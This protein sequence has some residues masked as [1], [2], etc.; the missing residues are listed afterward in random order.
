[1]CPGW[2]SCDSERSTLAR[3]GAAEPGV[4]ADGV[5]WTAMS[6]LDTSPGGSPPPLTLPHRDPVAV[7]LTSVIHGGDLDTLRRRLAERPEL[8][9]VRMIGRKGIEGGWRTP[10][11]AAADWPGYFPAAPAAV[12]LLLE[13]G[14]APNDDTGGDRPETPLHW[15]ASTDD[16]EVAVALIDGGAD[17]EVPGGS[18]GTPLDNAIGYSCCHVARL[19]VARGAKVDRLW[20]A[21]ALGMIERLEHLLGERTAAAG[22][23]SQ[24]FWHACAAGQRRAAEYLLAQ[25]ADL[26][27]VPEYAEGT[28]LDVARTLG[29]RKENVVS[30]LQER[31]AT[32]AKRPD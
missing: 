28:P 6:N 14:A 1:M 17:L 25:G 12:G 32:S 23:V 9:S 27:W 2:S 10:L 24:A 21:A 11:H 29:T 16:L 18:I 19:L 31:G 30:W 5:L 4:E 20:H 22:E 15:A 8:A 13:A 7:E 26:N 3:E